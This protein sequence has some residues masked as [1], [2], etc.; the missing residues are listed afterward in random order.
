MIVPDDVGRIY[1]FSRQP[2]RNL[3]PLASILDRHMTGSHL[4]L[5]GTAWT[6]QLRAPLTWLERQQ[7]MT[8]ADA[9]A[10][11]CPHLRTG[12]SRASGERLVDGSKS[13]LRGSSTVSCTA[14]PWA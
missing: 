2:V 6:S 12:A 1:I 11:L 3:L 14:A 5:V 13:K 9:R 4:D 10:R 7:D 8:A